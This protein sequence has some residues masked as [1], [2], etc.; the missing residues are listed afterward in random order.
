M[1]RPTIRT[2]I[3]EEDVAKIE[4]LEQQGWFGSRELEYFIKT[5]REH[6]NSIF[7]MVFTFKK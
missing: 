4:Y 5:A 6:K 1:I 3:D 2:L 7:S